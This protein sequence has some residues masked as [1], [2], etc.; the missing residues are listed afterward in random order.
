[1]PEIIHCSICGKPIRVE[2]FKDQMAKIRR[3]RKKY[4]PTAFKRS[5]EKGVRARKK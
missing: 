4:H 1:M 5:I 2:G 3:H